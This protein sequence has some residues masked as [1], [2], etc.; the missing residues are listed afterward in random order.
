MRV[1]LYWKK[2]CCFVI[3]KTGITTAFNSRT[4]RV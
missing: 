4:S 1:C 2:Q 3:D